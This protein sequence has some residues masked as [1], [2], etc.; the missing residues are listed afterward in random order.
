VLADDGLQHYALARDLEIVVVDAVRAFGNGWLMPAGPLRES[1]SRATGARAPVL[2]L[3]EDADVHV[4]L[5]GFRMPLR[6]LEWQ[7]LVHGAACPD[8]AALPSG[9]VH[10]VAGIAHPERF[11]A[12]VRARG[13][14][15][16]TH[17]FPDHHRFVAADLEFAGAQA[18]LMTEKDAVKCRA[19]ADARML[20]LPLVA[21]PDPALVALVEDTLH[22]SQA[23]RAPGMPRDQGPARL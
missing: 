18:I 5:P 17:P 3:P 15:A 20:W 11:F 19:I 6:T 16:V 2:A 13:I 21:A 9:T 8:P 7:P 23:A 10:A 1:T 12:A 22:G 14:A 4:A